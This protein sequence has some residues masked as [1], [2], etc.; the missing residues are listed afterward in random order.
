MDCRSG[1]GASLLRNRDKYSANVGIEKEEEGN[2]AAGELSCSFLLMLVGQL[3]HS[4]ASYHLGAYSNRYM[5]SNHSW[6]RR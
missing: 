1:G 3:V 4:F 2:S 5:L 6:Y